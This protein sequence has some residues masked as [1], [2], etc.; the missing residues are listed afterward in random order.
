MP[1]RALRDLAARAA[2]DRPRFHGAPRAAIPCDFGMMATLRAAQRTEQRLMSQDTQD[3]TSP[4][5][6]SPE[7][8]LDV[9]R[10]LMAEGG[11]SGVE[12]FIAGLARPSERRQLW[13]LAQRAFGQDEWDGKTLDVVI[14]IGRSAI[15]EGLRQA[16]AETDPEEAARRL[17]FANVMSYNLAAGLAPCWPDEKRHREPRHLEAGLKAAED[18]IRWREELGKGPGPRSMAL[19]AKGIH[20]LA[21]GRARQAREDFVASRDLAAENAR[22]A[23]HSVSVDETGHWS[24]LLGEGYVR[25]AELLAGEAGARERQDEILAILQAASRAQPDSRDDLHF[26]RDQLR[27]AEECQA[28]PR[29]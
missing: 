28:P 22:A 20:E 10:R 14:E 6:F 25:L 23:G 3:S 16:E 4:A 27:A 24:V 9:L 2:W 7:D 12:R 19:W 5:G 21:L 1:S 26:C 15:E 17:D 29:A 18:C 13:S 11:V 8:H